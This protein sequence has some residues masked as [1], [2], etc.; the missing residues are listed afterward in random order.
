MARSRTRRTPEP[1]QGE[2]RDGFKFRGGRVAL[3]FTATLAGRKRAE[4]TDLLR[5]PHD[6]V[7]WLAAAGL[8]P[9]PAAPAADELAG[10][11]ALREAIY[12][13]VTAAIHGRPLAAADRAAVNRCAALPTPVPQ[14]AADG[15]RAWITGGADAALAVVARDAIELVGAPAER[16]RLRACSGD[17]CAIV[18]F[19]ASRAGERRW[20]SMQGCGNRAKVREFRERARE[21]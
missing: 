10:A 19:D 16:G 9:L 12:R 18:F 1:P 2:L 4:P 6:L 15:H 3:D 7:R 13:L 11:R 5:E 14:L 21:S 20:C 8:G 17:G